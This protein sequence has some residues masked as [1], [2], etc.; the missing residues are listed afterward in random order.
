MWWITE[1]NLQL[2]IR[3]TLLAWVPPNHLTTLILRFTVQSTLVYT[4]SDS[5]AGTVELPV[6]SRKTVFDA[7]ACR[8]QLP[9]RRAPARICLG[10]GESVTVYVS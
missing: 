5:D 3:L 1:L 9:A 6:K 10:Y 4:T 8:M 7:R 2:R